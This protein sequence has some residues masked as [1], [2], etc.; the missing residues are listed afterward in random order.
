MKFIV[1]SL[2]ILGTVRSFSQTDKKIIFS[3][4]APAPIGP[5]SQAILVGNTLYVSGQIALKLDG[6]MDSSSIE[7]ETNLIIQTIKTILEAAEMDLKN[8]V[9]T[10]IYLTDL[11]NFKK[12]NDIYSKY[13]PENPPARETVEVNALPKGA[14]IEI[15]VI[16]LN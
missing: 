12:V 16:A 9:K 10:T 5:Y 15:S 7:N 1:L 8:I 14:H 2:L 4:K 3:N 6:N 11:K 13:F